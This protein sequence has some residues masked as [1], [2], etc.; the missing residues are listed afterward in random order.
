MG[1]GLVARLGREPVRSRTRQKGPAPSGKESL[2]QIPRSGR[3]SPAQPII[4][5]MKKKVSET[6]APPVTV[7]FLKEF[8]DYLSVEKGLSRNTTEAYQNDLENYHAFMEKE[9]AGGWGKITRSHIMDF[10]MH[11]KKRGLEASSIARRMVAIKVFH[12]FLVKE[13]LIAEDVT[14]V[15]ESPKLWKRL[16]K[17]LTVQD[18][19]RL[20]KI[21]EQEKLPL[22]DRALLELLYATGMRVSEIANLK[23]NDFNFDG[24]FVRCTGKGSKER[25]VPVGKSAMTYCRQYLDKVRTKENPDNS[26]F[27][28]GR[29]G[30]PL[31]RIFIWQQIKKYAKQAGIE[32]EITPHTFRHSFATHLLEGGADLRVVQ[33]LLG[34]SDIATT[35]IYT[36]V[37]RDRLKTIHAQFHP[38][39]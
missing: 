17:F 1:A 9:K 30:K 29:N 38:R 13:R 27:F 14:S 10:L 6:P 15:L 2:R 32:K 24:G 26:H 25:L 11:E 21:F 16:P 4:R 19:D 23:L 22:R 7:P 28:T 36:H 5:E 3:K 35:Q 18:M 31:S 34:H 37:S 12:R 33:E 39:A 8:L 20:L